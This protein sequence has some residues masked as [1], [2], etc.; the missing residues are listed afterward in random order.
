MK[1]NSYD[2]LGK[3][4][5]YYS[6]L[7]DY[8]SRLSARNGSVDELLRAELPNLMK[9]SFGSALHPLIHAGYG[10]SVGHAGTVL[11]GLAYM[12]H[13]Y[14]PFTFATRGDSVGSVL[15]NGSDDILEVLEAL[16]G[17]HGLY[18]Y[19]ES[20]LESGRAK[21]YSVGNAQVR[22]LILTDRGDDFLHYVS[23]IRSVSLISVEKF[24]FHEI[25]PKV[26]R[27]ESH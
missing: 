20:E 12:H 1:A 3:R 16:R 25:A 11:E 27:L 21:R 9:G 8:T 22:Y 18:R 2:I 4:V 7:R 23:R 10:Y 26:A 17:D 6:L 24:L 13:S 19:L 14:A 5:N 15:G